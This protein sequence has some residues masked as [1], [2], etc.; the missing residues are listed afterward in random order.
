MPQETEE[1]KNVRPTSRSARS[2]KPQKGGVSSTQGGVT[3]GETAEQSGSTVPVAP[4]LSPVPGD[5]GIAQSRAVRGLSNTRS[6]RP[7]R[8]PAKVGVCD[9]VEG[10]KGMGEGEVG[11]E[12]EEGTPAEC[13]QS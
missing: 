5:S 6:A 3:V 13:V 11:R 9:K 2:R 4:V 1:S 8:G 10:T 7:E 12:E